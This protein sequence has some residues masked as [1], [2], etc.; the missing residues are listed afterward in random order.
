MTFSQPLFWTQMTLWVVLPWL[1]PFSCKVGAG[2]FDFLISRQPRYASKNNKVSEKMKAG[3]LQDFLNYFE[4][5]MN[6]A[7]FIA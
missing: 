5:R 7:I 4:Y 3:P 6:T 1:Q 2:Y